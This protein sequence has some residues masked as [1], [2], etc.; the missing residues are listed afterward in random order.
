MSSD[1]FF[2]KKTPVLAKASIRHSKAAIDAWLADGDQLAQLL[3]LGLQLSGC[4]LGYTAIQSGEI[5]SV[6][7]QLGV[8][9]DSFAYEGSF[10]EALGTSEFLL[11]QG[12][13]LE[14]FRQNPLLLKHPKLTAVIVVALASHEKVNPGCLVMACENEISLSAEQQ[15]SCTVIGR[16]LALQLDFYCKVEDWKKSEQQLLQMNIELS[17]FASV[18]AHD[19]RSPLRAMGSFAGLLRR[20]LKQKLDAEELEYVD[21]I[22][23]GATR[24]SAMVEGI[25]NLAKA[26]HDD[27]S[28]YENID[29]PTL[30]AEVADLIDPD[31]H[32]IIDFEGD[33]RRIKSSLTAVKQVLLNLISNAVKYHHLT[34]GKIIVTATKVDSSYILRVTDNGPGIAI[35][36]QERIFEAFVTGAETP[37]VPGTGLGLA[38]VRSVVKRLDGSLSLVSAPGEGSTFEVK[39]PI[40]AI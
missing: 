36:D 23:S 5:L 32:H 10:F 19:L 2:A 7:A 13:E 12:A 11:L 15:A 40:K 38:L 17:R 14:G 24:L 31:Q 34:S 20:R 1:I 6:G 27:F 16:Q 4:Q 33:Q 30:V 25:L 28:N 21:H 37:R 29:L 22:R 3:G 35:A 18:A 9:F 8:E 39:L 26:N